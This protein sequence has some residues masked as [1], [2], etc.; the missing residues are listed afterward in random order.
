MSACATPGA[1]VQVTSQASGSPYFSL[2]AP[3]VYKVDG[4]LRLAGRVC[5]R[6]RTTLLSP[7]RI[8]L[9]HVAASGEVADVARASVA[10]IYRNADQACS[11]YAVRVAWQIADGEAL[12]ACFDRGRPCPSNSP[13]KALIPVPDSAR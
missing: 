5:R 1:S 13:N 2:G 6:A 8:R 3:G 4:G 7:S 11:S 12:R 9:E 10:A